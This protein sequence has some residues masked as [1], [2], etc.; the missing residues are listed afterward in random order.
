MGEIRILCWLGFLCPCG[1]H[2]SI[3]VLGFWKEQAVRRNL[4]L[5]ETGWNLHSEIMGL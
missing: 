4:K 3:L 2:F 1:G 5:G